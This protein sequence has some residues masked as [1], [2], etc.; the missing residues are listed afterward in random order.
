MKNLYLASY[1]LNT[2]VKTLMELG[3]TNSINFQDICI[4][5]VDK[6]D[7][8][9]LFEILNICNSYSVMVTE[10]EKKIFNLKAMV[11]NILNN[12]HQLKWNSFWNIDGIVYQLKLMKIDYKII[13]DNIILY[14]NNVKYNKDVKYKKI[15]I[16]LKDWSIQGFVLW[17]NNF[18][19]SS[20]LNLNVELHP[21]L[22]ERYLPYGRNDYIE[23][24]FSIENFINAIVD[25]CTKFDN[26]NNKKIIENYL[27]C[28][29][30]YKQ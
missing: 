24:C 8:S 9:K 5:Y 10:Y 20:S 21:N 30:L 15:A 14:F 4:K 27:L 22:M 17:F 7:K 23:F 25:I 18:M 29:N 13:D 26:S 11:K 12:N 1:I 2:S 3:Y 28:K 6:N 16:I 19:Y